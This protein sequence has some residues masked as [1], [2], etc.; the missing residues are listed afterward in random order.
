MMS[1][2][3]PLPLLPALHPQPALA[4]DFPIHIGI[5]VSESSLLECSSGRYTASDTVSCPVISFANYTARGSDELLSQSGV[6]VMA[7]A[8]PHHADNNNQD[9]AAKKV[10]LQ[11]Q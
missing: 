1:C 4:S 3:L 7:P 6:T 9:S 2:P 5:K 10:C 11:L 8:A